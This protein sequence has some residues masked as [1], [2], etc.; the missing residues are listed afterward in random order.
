MKKYKK[1]V[2]SCN[3]F[4]W[5]K[6]KLRIFA[7]HLFLCWNTDG[8]QQKLKTMFIF[9][10]PQKVFTYKQDYYSVRIRLFEIRP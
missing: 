7:L 3:Y 8:Y 4:L 1:D 10:I 5:G 9:H 6:R 2:Y